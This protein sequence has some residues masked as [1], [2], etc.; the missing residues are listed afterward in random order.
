MDFLEN[1]SSKKIKISKERFEKEKKLHKGTGKN[2]KCTNTDIAEIMCVDPVTVSSYKYEF[3]LDRLQLLC[4]SWGVRIE[5]LQGIDSFRTDSDILQYLDNSNY[6]LFNDSAKLCELLG[7]KVNITGRVLMD[8]SEYKEEYG[9]IILDDTNGLGCIIEVTPTKENLIHFSN[10]F[11]I[12][13]FKNNNLIAEF[14]LIDFAQKMRTLILSA[15]N[16][17]DIFVYDNQRLRNENE[18]RQKDLEIYAK[19]IFKN[20]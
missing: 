10:R 13:V 18:Q 19:A 15:K 5:Y 20:K 8:K 16:I 12:S 3:P 14:T 7:Y 4:D 17:F 2:E 11:L 6:K 1:N 9:E